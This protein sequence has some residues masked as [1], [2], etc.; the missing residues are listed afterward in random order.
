MASPD[1]DA[2]ALSVVLAVRNGLPDIVD[3]LRSLA[4]QEVAVPWEL[5]VVDDGS[6]DGTR[7]AVDTA[8]DR[9]PVRSI[10][11]PRR[12]SAAARNAGVAAT[13]APLLLF[14]DHDDEL[15]PGYLA[16]MHE[17]LGSDPLVIARFDCETLNPGWIGRY[18]PAPQQDGPS[19]GLSPFGATAAMGITRSLFE[20]L[21][22]FDESM[23][24][25][26]DRDLCYRATA[27]GAAPVFVAEAV[28]RYRYRTTLRGIFHQAR[29]GGVASARLYARY[30]VE[31]ARPRLVRA[32]AA[33]ALRAARQLLRARSIA[34]RA[35]PVHRLGGIAGYLEGSIRTRILYLRWRIPAP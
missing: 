4:A 6:T 17:A 3:Q 25:G 14:V 34:D 32:E 12:G 10:A 21:H 11:G 9:L 20:E 13:S 1:D 18:R 8:A 29:T 35:G 27:R 28:L 5:V 19:I 30:R 33:K 16:A 7:A 24:P 22:G 2:P 23:T 15:A 31:G 26:E